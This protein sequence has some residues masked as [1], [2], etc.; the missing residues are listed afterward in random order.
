M[1][2]GKTQLFCFLCVLALGFTHQDVESQIAEKFDSPA[3]ANAPTLPVPISSL[4]NTFFSVGTVVCQFP[5][6][7]KGRATAFAFCSDNTLI[8]CYHVF[9]HP[10]WG[11][12]INAEFFTNE[13]K[14]TVKSILFSARERD[15]AVFEVDRALQMPRLEMR[16]AYPKEWD[17]VFVL[18]CPTPL[19][20]G[21]SMIM[22]GKFAGYQKGYGMFNGTGWSLSVPGWPSCSGGVVL[23]SDGYLIAI[24]EGVKPI[25]AA[26][27]GVSGTTVFAIPIEY[28][29]DLTE[30]NTMT[31]TNLLNQNAE[32]TSE[33]ECIEKLIR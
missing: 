15:L 8:T 19:P 31:F 18:V 27:G 12:A 6:G 21:Y 10:I 33:V 22:P 29:R 11:P 16:V 23:D 25:L 17:D 20:F 3:Y 1:K 30:E 28:L 4:L 24:I 26:N 2:N 14:F 5:S 32:D 9:V 7:K 13:K